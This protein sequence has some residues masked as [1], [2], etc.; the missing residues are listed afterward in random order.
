MSQNLESEINAV[1]DRLYFILKEEFEIKSYKNEN[2][3][4]EICINLPNQS[5]DVYITTNLNKHKFYETSYYCPFHN[6]KREYDF[7]IENIKTEAE[8]L[9]I[10]MPNFVDIFANQINYWLR[11]T[12]HS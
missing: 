7:T 11:F 3:I 5:F 6:N 9:I 12:R 10:R 1:K 8:D 4:V 2:D